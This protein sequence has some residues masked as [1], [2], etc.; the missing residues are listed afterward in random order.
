MKGLD[1]IAHIYFI[2]IG[3]IGMSALA[4]YFHA[5]GV[6]VSGYDRTATTLTRELEAAGFK[7]TSRGTSGY[8]TA[9]IAEWS[10]G[11]GGGKIGFLP[12]YDALPG[13][14]N[15]PVSE[16]APR[17][18]DKTTGHGCGHNL[19]GAGCTGAA[20]ALKGIMEKESVP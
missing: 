8:P 17:S 20:I 12:E 19:W 3:G 14:G 7:V 11:E 6:A 16:Q 10:Q 13:L 4:R 18:D 5:R 1:N 9:F 15:A 2:G